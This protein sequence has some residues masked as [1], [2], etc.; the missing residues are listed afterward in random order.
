MIEAHHRTEGHSVAVKFIR[1]R[2]V[3]PLAWT[4]DNEGER[5]PS[6]VRLMKIATHENIVRSLDVFQDNDFIYIVSPIY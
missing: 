6:E 4:Q 3:P 5:L 1:K 2:T